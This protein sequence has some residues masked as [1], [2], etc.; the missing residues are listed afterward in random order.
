[1][2]HVIIPGLPVR[3]M[4]GIAPFFGLARFLRSSLSASHTYSVASRERLTP[5]FLPLV[6]PPLRIAG[7]VMAQ[8][9]RV[10]HAEVRGQLQSIDLGGQVSGTG[11]A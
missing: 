9:A 3:Y 6:P 7:I 10:L 8:G 5:K 1:M 2:N 11:V 4:P